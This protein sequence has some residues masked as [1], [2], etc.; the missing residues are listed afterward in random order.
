LG[1]RKLGHFSP[2]LLSVIVKLK[3]KLSPTEDCL[4]CKWKS[5]H[6]D[7][8]TPG[9]NMLNHLSPLQFEAKVL[10]DVIHLFSESWIKHHNW[11]IIG[12][13]WFTISLIQRLKQWKHICMLLSLVV[14]HGYTWPYNWLVNLML[15]NIL[16]LTYILFNGVS[17]FPTCMNINILMLNMRRSWQQLSLF[18][19][20]MDILSVKIDQTEE[21]NLCYNQMLHASSILSNWGHIHS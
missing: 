9:I 7:E 19:W 4:L 3:I 5:F 20:I 21:L 1:P 16:Y 17:H 13:R 6:L 10:F 2:H 12:I 14:I 8:S 18:E 11:K 15:K